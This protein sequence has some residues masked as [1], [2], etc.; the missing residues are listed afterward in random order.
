MF[1]DCIKVNHFWQRFKLWL[2]MIEGNFVNLSTSNIIFEIHWLKNTYN[3]LYIAHK[4]VYKCEQAGRLF[5]LQY[6]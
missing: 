3:F 6:F 5:K 2:G 4:M 1:V